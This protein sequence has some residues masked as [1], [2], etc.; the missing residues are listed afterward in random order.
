MINALPP[1]PCNDIFHIFLY[2]AI[3]WRLASP[4]ACVRTTNFANQTRKHE[5]VL[6][7]EIGGTS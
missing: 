1:P 4:F 2:D 3:S 7:M 5:F 6:S